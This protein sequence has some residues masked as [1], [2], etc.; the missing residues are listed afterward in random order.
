MDRELTKEI[1]ARVDATQ[2]SPSARASE[3]WSVVAQLDFTQWDWVCF[4]AEYLG[5]M[6][7]AIPY[8]LEPSKDL[9]KRVYTAHYLSEHTTEERHRDISGTDG[10]R[11]SNASSSDDAPK[12]LYLLDST[13]PREEQSNRESSGSDDGTNGE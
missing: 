6:S 13:K 7:A 12:S 4:C 10:S 5:M 1:I 3:V 9:S 2:L 8:L 11:S